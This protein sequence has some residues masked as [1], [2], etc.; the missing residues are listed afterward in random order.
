[1]FQ[2]LI[3]AAEPAVVPVICRDIGSKASGFLVSPDGYMITSN[4]V[5][6]QLTLQAGV[7]S[8]SYSS[9][10]DVVVDGTDYRARL[11]SDPN[12]DRPIVY[13]YA[14]LKVEGLT[15]VPHLDLGDSVAV[16]RGDDVLC[17]GFP[18]DFDTL[19]AT[20][21]I[22]SAV[23]RRP[24]HV[25]ALHQ[26]STIVSNALM[27]YGSSGGPMLHAGTGR[28]IGIN[29]LRHELR[30]RLEQRLRIWHSHP[31]AADF[32]L[33][34]DLVGYSLKYTH[35][36]LNHAVSVEHVQSD[37]AWPKHMER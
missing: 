6:A 23:L 36:G 10:I 24:S 7:L 31:G 35:V 21:G 11:V 20:N 14:I 17:L 37:T 32:S 15:N 28:V 25:N 22:V 4:H 1:M 26:M 9:M 12:D 33:L 5:V 27:Q 8:A 16:Q 2:A 13:D 34:R 30:D 3:A 19:I 29:T 18:L